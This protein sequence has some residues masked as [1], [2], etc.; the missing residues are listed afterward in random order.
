MCLAFERASEK[1][2]DEVG[3]LAAKLIEEKGMNPEKAWVEAERSIQVR[4]T[5]T[6]TNLSKDQIENLMRGSEKQVLL[7]D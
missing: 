4:R 7:N 6:N 5:Y 1:W 2:R 3:A